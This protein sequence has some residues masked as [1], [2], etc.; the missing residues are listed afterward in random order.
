MSNENQ[1][2][3]ESFFLDNQ[4]VNHLDELQ[5]EDTK[6]QME[7]KE[8][9]NESYYEGS[10]TNQI[11][12]TNK[13]DNLFDGVPEEAIRQVM[14]MRQAQE[15]LK[16]R[17]EIEMAESGINLAEVTAF[18]NV[19]KT[20]EEKILGTKIILNLKHEKNKFNQKERAHILKNFGFEEREIRHVQ[21]FESYRL[22]LS[23]RNMHNISVDEFIEDNKN[24]FT[25]VAN[26]TG[27]NKQEQE[28]ANK[29]F[30]NLWPDMKKYWSFVMALNYYE[31]VLNIYETQ[32]FNLERKFNVNQ[33]NTS[34]NRLRAG[35]KMQ[36]EHNKM[37][38][39]INQNKPFM[40]TRNQDDLDIMVRN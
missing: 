36:M 30:D 40:L 7:T 24:Y 38:T 19:Y 10:Y 20:P 15:N 29:N 22:P 35:L 23:K 4:N 21:K 33:F 1:Y 13:N 2:K 34:I 5:N 9:F 8:Q 3:I 31:R 18:I 39:D 16:N 28:S 17:A 32:I 37:D 26:R 6:V 14:F 27:I 12:G 25:V 11:N